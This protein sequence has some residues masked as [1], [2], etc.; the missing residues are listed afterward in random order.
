MAVLKS[1]A[2]AVAAIPPTGLTGTEKI[3]SPL[4][5]Y[6]SLSVCVC[7]SSM[8]VWRGEERGGRREER[9]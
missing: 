8:C 5:I 3:R 2:A 6:I 1:T 9:A 7:E 4:Y